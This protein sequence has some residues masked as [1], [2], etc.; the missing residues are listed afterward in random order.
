MSRVVYERIKTICIFILIIAGILQVGILWG[1]QSQG[2]PIRFLLGLF[3]KDTQISSTVVQEKLFSPDRLVL[4]KGDRSH[5]I[6]GRDSDFYEELW[7]EAK[8]SLGSIA[9]G[10]V[11]LTLS[12]EEWGDIAEKRGFIA[13]FGYVIDPELLKWFLGA[14]DKAQELPAVQKLMIKP[15]IVDENASVLYIYGID[16]RVYLSDMIRYERN[17]GFGDIISEVAAAK[18]EYREYFTLRG[19]KIDKSMGAEPDVLYVQSS[20]TYWQYYQ[21]RSEPPAKGGNKDELSE[22]VLGNEKERY[23]IRTGS[24]GTFQFS[25]GSNL[26]KYYTDGYLTYQY[27]GSVSS[28]ARGEVGDALMNAY[29]LIA[30]VSDL[31]GADVDIALTSVEKQKQGVYSFSF[32]YRLENMTV[33]LDMDMKDGNGEKLTHAI[34]IVADS[35][36]VLKCDWLL[37]DFIKDKK[38]NYDDRFIELVKQTGLTHEEMNIRDMRFGYSISS[39]YESIL[40]PKLLIEMKDKTSLELALKPEKG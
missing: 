34:N 30:R 24:D 38:S 27:L 16:G 13:D 9:S 2:T 37:R 32:D 10:Q 17:R 29:K 35:R 8:Q 23:N 18:Q 21:Y 25:Y 39:T 28:S 36:R 31:Y 15:D 14:G 3:G 40:E 11:S 5:W 7:N 4:S 1:Y 22:I 33:K 26:Y 20:P 12:D 19:S 6:I